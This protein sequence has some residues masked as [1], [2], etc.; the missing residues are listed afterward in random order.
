M[1]VHVTE[2]GTWRRTLEVEV[3]P[4]AVERKFEAA[5]KRYGKSLNLPGFRKGKVPLRLVK[6]RFGKAIQGE[7]LQEIINASYQ[8]ARESEDLHPVSEATV[9]DMDHAE[10]RPLRFKV[11]VDVKPELDVG[12]YKGLSVV[13]PVFKVGPETEERQL[14][15]LQ[16]QHAVEQVVDRPADLGDVLLMDLQESDASGL[17]IIGRKQEGQT[18]RLGSGEAGSHDLENQ[19]IGIRVGEQR[20]VR[21]TQTADGETRDLHFLVTAKEV[22]ERIVPELDDEF[23]QD[24]GD[25]DSLDALKRSI[26][27]DLHARADFGSRVRFEENIVDSLI[28]SN[29]FDVPESMVESYLDVLIENHKKENEKIDEGAIRSESRQGAI[30][31]VKRHLLLEAVA[32]LEGIEVT[33]EDIDRHLES[34][35][36]R[37]KVESPRLRKILDRS[38]QLDR[39][40]SELLEGKT[41]DFLGKSA[42]VKE[43]EERV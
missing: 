22:R 23:A 17:P 12:H 16:D 15:T 9:E 31:N 8:E 39:I 34:L 43:V 27:E 32:R 14:K 37:H 35:S 3:P 42:E 36:L 41:L 19:L 40:R 33:E 4:E 10:G 5:Y 30:R 11:S 24:L 6:S 13:R 29:A 38:G 28:R 2:S 18:L 1:K 21:F 25:Y 26:R 7:V 20:K